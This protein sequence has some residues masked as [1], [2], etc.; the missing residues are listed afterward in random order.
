MRK[1]QTRK[2]HLDKMWP[3]GI[4]AASTGTE[5]SGNMRV[6]LRNTSSEPLA[7]KIHDNSYLSWTTTRSVV[8]AHMTSVLLP[9]KQSHGWYDFT[10][11][12]KGSGTEARFAVP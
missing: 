3:S 12:L 6:N 8:P 4:P 11:K 2:K 7:I 1:G 5:L 9:L 10:V